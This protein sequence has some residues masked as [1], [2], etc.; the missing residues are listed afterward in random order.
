[1]S[2]KNV[3]QSAKKYRF[4]AGTSKFFDNEAVIKMNRLKT[5]SNDESVSEYESLIPVQELEDVS[6]EKGM[7]TSVDF[8]PVTNEQFIH[9]ATRMETARDCLQQQLIEDPQTLSILADEYLSRLTELVDQSEMFSLNYG[10]QNADAVQDK[11]N[12]QVNAKDFGFELQNIFRSLIDIKKTGKTDKR[13]ADYHQVIVDIHFLPIFL[14]R[15]VCRVK[16]EALLNDKKQSS[17]QQ[18]LKEMLAARQVIINSNIRMVAFIVNKYSH[19]NIAFSDLMQE[20]TI[21]LI[22]AVDRFDYLRPVKF[23]TYGVYWIRQMI[24]RCITKQRK[25]VSLPFNLATKIS[26]VFETIN[27]YIQNHDKWP[28]YPELADL[29]EMNLNE[30]EAIMEFYRPCISLTSNAYNDEEMPSVLDTLEQHHFE[31]PINELASENL[32]S[33]LRHAIDSLSDREAY[34]IRTR[35]GL[36]TG[37]ELTL[38][39]IA[40]QFHVSKERVRQIQN[41]ALSKL[42]NKFGHDLNDFLMA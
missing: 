7:L 30:I 3:K 25:L 33:N 10:K 9:Y 19:T 28:T 13:V 6:P 15:V 1:M 41:T 40:D 23:S 14:Q 35:F 36:T 22:K 12:V 11:E 5:K 26:L 38:Q 16:E 39:D 37:I 42:R 32:H 17:L 31:S 4:Q 24:S 2:M 21:G 20:G 34:V 18:L 27:T 8:E 29:C